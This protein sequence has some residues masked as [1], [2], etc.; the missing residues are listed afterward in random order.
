MWVNSRW[1][2][3]V[4]KFRRNENYPKYRILSNT[5]DSEKYFLFF[6][7]MKEDFG[8]GAYFKAMFGSY[9][10]SNKLKISCF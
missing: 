6:F 8:D 5:V 10:M 7:F 1:G 4:Y 2:K 3:A 9:K